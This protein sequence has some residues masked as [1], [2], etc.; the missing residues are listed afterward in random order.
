MNK[1]NLKIEN[2][3]ILKYNLE[4]YNLNDTIVFGN[5]PYNISTQ[6]LVKFISVK[7]WPTFLIK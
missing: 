6:I 2:K 5:L 4:N 1:K 7:K 3:D